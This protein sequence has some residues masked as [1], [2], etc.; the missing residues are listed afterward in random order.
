M[1]PS[2]KDSVQKARCAFQQ[3]SQHPLSERLELIERFRRLL[4][5]KRKTVSQLITAETGKPISESLTEV[6]A[7]LET[8]KWLKKDCAKILKPELLKLNRLFFGS[9]RNKVQ[10]EPLGVIAVISPWNFPLSIPATGVLTALATGN[11][12]LLKPSPK[13]SQV[14]GALA[15]LL[16]EAG[17]PDDVL[18]VIHGDKE[19]AQAL[20][21]EGLDRVVFTGSVAGGRA[22]MQLAAQNLTP[23]TL[24]LGGKH[25]AIVLEDADLERCADAILWSAFTNAGQACASIER[26]YVVESKHDDLLKLLQRKVSKLRLGAP[27]DPRTDVGPMIDEEQFKRVRGMIDKACQQGASLVCGGRSLAEANPKL[28][29]KLKGFYLEPTILAG[30]KPDME[31]LQEE[32][33][34]PV[35]PVVQV[36]NRSEAIALA[37]E[38]RYGLGASVW[39]NDLVGAEAVAARIRAGMVWINDGLFSHACPEAPWGGIK[40]SG[41]GR[42]HGK[43]ALLDFVNIKLVSSDKPGRRNWN[44]PYSRAQLGLIDAAICKQN[45]PTF[46]GR[47]WASVRLAFNWLRTR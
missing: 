4:L 22:I 30:V 44:F 41:S 15:D 29:A 13:A 12:V 17:L 37:N 19:E 36:R 27:L 34:G 39:S 28:A 24:E 45:S 2:I 33:F 18:Q 25:P 42:T 16:H 21:K 43:H 10:L 8:C 14:A 20:L 47:L 3:W 5:K 7:V 11:C 9:K 31:I 40:Y 26:L 32:I 35:L 38:S 1:N 23:V 46:V 6:F